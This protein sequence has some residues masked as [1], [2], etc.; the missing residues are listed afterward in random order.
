MA[1]L[2][3]MS[4]VLAALLAATA[5]AND[6]T[7]LTLSLCQASSPCEG[8]RTCSDAQITTQKTP[9]P[10]Q[11]GSTPPV[12]VCLPDELDY[13]TSD[14]P[15]ADG[16]VCAQTRTTTAFCVDEATVKS[17][18]ALFGIDE[19]A[20]PIPPP[21]TNDLSTVIAS[22]PRAKL[23]EKCSDPL[24]CDAGLVCYS[25][26]RTTPFCEMGEDCRCLKKEVEPCGDG[27][28][29][30]NTVCSAI[31]AGEPLCVDDTTVTALAD[32]GV[33]VT[34]PGPPTTA[35]PTTTEV[36]ETTMVSGPDTGETVPGPESVDTP[37]PVVTPA[38]TEVP[39]PIT[40]GVPVG[41]GTSTPAPTAGPTDVPSS[42]SDDTSDGDDDSDAEE[43]ETDTNESTNPVPSISPSVED[44][45]SDED[46]TSAE[47]TSVPTG[48]PICIAAKHLA[49]LSKSELVFTDHRLTNVLCDVNGSCATHG[50][51]VVYKGQ[52]MMMRSY[53]DIT[54]C[55][56]KRMHVNSPAY[57][58]QLRV[59]APTDGLEFTALA[60]RYA[61]RAE[62]FAL[63]T[64]VRVGL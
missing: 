44:P 52:G 54:S 51:V 16:E 31:I 19:P 49:H 17:T 41:P 34:V 63:V 45:D 53:C 47:A 18:E 22:F 40:P 29:A 13:C 62:E 50:H 3:S 42:G 55:V 12:C 21:D 48:E 11:V 1:P 10:P 64:A 35:A 36:S 6:P 58:K 33:E 14:G 5:M 37:A 46:G 56:E 9:C 2:R 23:A 25:F 26:G 24:A 60:A 59:N 28:C 57:R 30:G 15:C 43:D 61:T 4:V 8:T 38:P 27:S 20:P 7:G 32:E 39:I